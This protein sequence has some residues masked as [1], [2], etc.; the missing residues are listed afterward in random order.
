MK[1]KNELKRIYIKNCVCYYFDDIINGTKMNFSNFS[2]DKNLNENISVYNVL[3]KTPADPKPL[4][5][6]FEKIDG[7]VIAL[8]GKNKHLILFDQ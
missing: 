6:R 5:I 8:D 7:F 3:Y 1:S 4:C 2:L